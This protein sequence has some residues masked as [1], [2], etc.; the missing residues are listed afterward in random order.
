M[1]Y[2]ALFTLLILTSCDSLVQ[3]VPP[4]KL[5]KVDSQLT[6]FGFISPQDTIIRVKVSQ[7]SPILS[8]YSYG[9]GGYMV[10][11]GD[12][13]RFGDAVRDA[14]VTLSDGVAE[15]VL[16]FQNK[17]QFYAIPASRFSIKAGKMYK[18]TASD[19]KRTIMATCTVP[20]EQLAI[21]KYTLDTTV[22][23]RFNRVDTT[24]V[25]SF[26]WDD[27]AGKAS[28]YRMKAYEE[29]EIPYFVFNTS[30]KKY[31]EKRTIIQ[32]YFANGNDT[33]SDL[34]NDTNLDG[35]TFSSARLE[36]RIGL[37]GNYYNYPHVDGKPL[38]PEK[39]PKSL[40]VHLL[41]LHT[42]RNYFEFHRSLR[43]Q[44]GD[45]PF[46]EPSLIY[47]N[48]KGGFGIFASYNMSTK[49]IRP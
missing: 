12:T 45:N 21:K 14:K 3:T 20:S 26:T 22:T 35:Q 39:A 15:V 34:Q 18:L 19:G 37:L 23:K 1:K 11:N 4:D 29:I 44:N 42:D 46:T 31:Y 13:T 32:A 24:L 10:S 2:F 40:G 28:Y 33:R 30:E 27:V 9:S 43:L 48:V 47:T 6:M 25:T 16:P 41:L 36:K 38:V 7:T 5:T 49:V 17:G 8:D